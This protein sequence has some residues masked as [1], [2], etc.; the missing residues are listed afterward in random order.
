MTG[1]RPENAPK[2]LPVRLFTHVSDDVDD[3]LRLYFAISQ[4]P[5]AHIV[6][7]IL[8]RMLPSRAQIM[9]GMGEGKDNHDQL[10]A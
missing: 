3:R 2:K 8:D 7:D 4:T 1:K 5:I 9:A 6:N 10:S